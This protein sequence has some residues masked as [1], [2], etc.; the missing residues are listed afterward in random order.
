MKRLMILF[1]DGFPYERSEPFLEREHPLYKKYFDH[2]LIST[3]CRRNATPTRKLEDPGIEVVPD[4]TLGKDVKS[5]I[6]AIPWLLT[7]R[8]F[9]EELYKLV[10]SK[11]F[12]RK[13]L[14]QLL[15]YAI[16]GNH[17]AKEI[18]K[19]I[20][21]HSEYS[22]IVLYSYWMLVPAYAADRLNRKMGNTCYTVSRAH[23]WDLYL[24]RGTEGYHPFHE[25]LYNRLDEV[26]VI[27]KQG[28][29]YLEEHYGAASKVTVHRLGAYDQGLSN[30]LA[31]RDV[32][33]IVTC[34]RTIP[35]KR[36]DRLVDALS[37]LSYPVH[38]THLGG[39]EAQESLERDASEKLPPNVEV[40][41]YGTVPNTKV[42]EV[43]AEQPFHVFVNIS[44]TEGVP[45][46][47]M[48]A[49]SFHIPV[50][51][52]DVGGTSELVD[53]GENG[54]LLSADF[55]DEELVSAIN[56][57]YMMP[58]EQYELYRKNARRKFVQDYDATE[59]YEAF[60]KHLVC[61]TKKQ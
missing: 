22:D 26:A 2:V 33:R 54:I 10:L 18:H 19:W 58:Q 17:R 44:S 41:F 57:F 8:A 46:S 37:M 39:G 24:E 56:R 14:Y 36:L 5:I 21:T 40:E 55:R 11:E 49:M 12:S 50:I 3:A 16:C 20:K 13:K 27:S 52:T 23:G 34:S 47:I 53:H 32:L 6:G 9:Y 29:K 30:P 38:W 25:Y 7:D 48:E 60:L 43:L 28:K 51:A 15:V 4:Y 42:Y 35:L 31:A 45:V 1:A 61:G 59:N